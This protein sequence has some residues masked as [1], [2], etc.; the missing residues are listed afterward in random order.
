MLV[1]GVSA[2][3]QWECLY[4]TW[5]NSANGTGH[6]VMSVGVI[7]ENMFVAMV[8]TRATRNFLIPY[9]NA[10]SGLGRKYFYGYGSTILSGVYQ[11]WTDGGWI[12][13]R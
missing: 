5:D 6:Q 2:N 3:A 8:T 4:A 13:C 10:D 7:K 9:V 1:L 12:R 11:V